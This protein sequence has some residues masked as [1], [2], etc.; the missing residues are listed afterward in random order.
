MNNIWIATVDPGKKNFAF[1]IQEIDLDKFNA[2]KFVNKDDRYNEDGT[3]TRAFKSNIRDICKCSKVILW[4]NVDITCGTKKYFDDKLLY[5]LTSVLDSFKDYWD[6]CHYVII[7]EQMAF[8]TKH[9]TMAIKVAQHTQ[10]YFIFNY[11]RFKTIVMFQAYHKTKVLGAL[12]GITKPQRK[13][14]S[15]EFVKELIDDVACENEISEQ[16][17]K[18]KKKD[19]YSDVMLMVYA[20][21][22]KYFKK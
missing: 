2:I 4:K 13:K 7:E 17:K 19:D 16:Y 12:K 9:N 15:V 8:G 14:W 1:I 18:S 22:I 21:L 6:K 20:F 11:F 3:H 10:S 5:E